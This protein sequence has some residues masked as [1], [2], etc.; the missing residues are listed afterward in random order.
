VASEGTDVVDY[1]DEARTEANMLGIY[2]PIFINARQR[3]VM[4]GF[5]YLINAPQC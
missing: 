5:M 1:C 3:Q 2:F 4:S